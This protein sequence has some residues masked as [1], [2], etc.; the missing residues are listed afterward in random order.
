MNKIDGL[1]VAA[2]TPMKKDGSINPEQVEPLYNYYRQNGIKGV[3]INGSTGEGLSLTFKERLELCE[4]WSHIVDDDFKLIVHIGSNSLNEAKE[5]AIHAGINKVDGISTIGPFYQKSATVEILV[6]ICAQV[7]AQAPDIPFYYYHIPI[8][9]GIHFS[10]LH[11]LEHA[12]KKIPSLAGIKFSNSDLSEYNLCRVFE[13]EKY[14][15][16]YGNDEMF[17]ACLATGGKGFVGSTYNMFPRLYQ[18]IRN[19]YENNRM[20]RARKL[21]VKAIQF[22]NVLAKYNYNAASKAS[23]NM[24]GVDCGPSR[25]P[26]RELSGS[27]IISLKNDL[28]ECGF[29]DYAL[30]AQ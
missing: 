2:F 13:N 14:D 22:V 30:I 5:F 21:Q 16:M 24:I 20:D 11:F 1:I 9:T 15:I 25:L 3:F 18:E 4:A 26:F 28:E 6:E 12:S 10:M 23:M 17:L 19:A 29:F 27:E 7:A 8:L